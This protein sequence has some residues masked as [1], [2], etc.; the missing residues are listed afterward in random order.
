MN[1]K[2]TETKPTSAG[3]S[4]RFMN[5]R[6]VIYA[7]MSVWI[8]LM[9]NGPILEAATLPTA[10]EVLQELNISDSD[11]QSIREGKIVK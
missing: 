2:M 6:G 9:F 11:Q 1:P 8:G 7:V 4:D 5:H 10:D 3:F